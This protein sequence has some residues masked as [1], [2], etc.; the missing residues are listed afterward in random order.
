MT[1]R[2][3]AAAI[4]CRISNDPTGLKAGVKRQEDD[5]RAL[6]KRKGWTVG[7]VF[8]DDDRSAYSGKPRPQ[9]REMLKEIDA[10]RI[11]AV[12]VYHLDRLHRNP[13]ELEVFF[14]T[15]DR[16]G[17]RNLASVQGDVDLATDDGRLHARILGAV[18]R[19]S[20]DDT[21]R[22]L[23]R[24]FEE[25]AQNGLPAGGWRPFGYAAEE[26]PDPKTKK[27]TRRVLTGR[28]VPAEA[29]LIKEIG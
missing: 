27:G 21:S 5:C 4:Y 28:L 26:I 10:G 23:K 16:A 3:R 12:I 14:E 8:T 7:Q 11:D 20:S 17:L 25:E 19:K 29:K 24:K 9:Y 6:A 2:A 15:C 22:R 13:K 1:A 18:A